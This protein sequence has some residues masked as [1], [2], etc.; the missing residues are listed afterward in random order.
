MSVVKTFGTLAADQAQTSL[1][2][3]KVHFPKLTKNGVPIYESISLG[4]FLICIRS[5]DLLPL[6]LLLFF[7]HFLW[8]N[9]FVG[10][11]AL[12]LVYQPTLLTMAKRSVIKM[13]LIPESEELLIQKVGLM[14]YVNTLRVKINDVEYVDRE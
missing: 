1:Q 5:I 3:D 12:V 11:L 6:P 4:T 13:E 9:M 8:L 14:G 7:S 10:T 2:S